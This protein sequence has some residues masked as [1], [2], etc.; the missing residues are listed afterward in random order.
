MLEF[1]NHPCIV[2]IKF[3]VLP[4]YRW[5]LLSRKDSTWLM[6]YHLAQLYPLV[7]L[8][9]LHPRVLLLC[10]LI[11]I[12]RKPLCPPVGA[13]GTLPSCHYG[14]ASHSPCVHPVPFHPCGPE[15]CAVPAPLRLGMHIADNQNRWHLSAARCY[16]LGCL[17]LVRVGNPSCITGVDRRWSEPYSYI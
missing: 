9:V 12:W 13:T 14:V 17:L 10:Q 8:L 2:G 16:A 15:Q 1:Q 3:Y 6:P 7:L 11:V 4:G 5:S